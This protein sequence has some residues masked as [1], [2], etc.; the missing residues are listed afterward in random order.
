[1]ARSARCSPVKLIPSSRL[2]SETLGARARQLHPQLGKLSDNVWYCQEYSG[3]GIATS[4]VMGEIMAQ[5]ITGTL[6]RLH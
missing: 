2:T 6:E 5:A 4:H 3:H 1:M